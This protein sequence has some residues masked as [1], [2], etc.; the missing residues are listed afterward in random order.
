MYIINEISVFDIYEKIYYVSFF[1]ILSL[2][3]EKFYNYRDDFMA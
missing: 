2:R 3:I 1:K